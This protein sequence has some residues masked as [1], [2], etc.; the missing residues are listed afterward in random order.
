[1]TPADEGFAAAKRDNE[2]NDEINIDFVYQ[3]TD[4][5]LLLTLLNPKTDA[6]YYL[7]KELA[8][9]GLDNDGLW[10]GFAKAKKIHRV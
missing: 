9:R 7:K 6:R 8:N 1:M 10:V 2:K 4:T 5:E 3:Q